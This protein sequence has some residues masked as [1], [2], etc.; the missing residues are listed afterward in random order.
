MPIPPDYDEPTKKP[1]TFTFPQLDWAFL[2]VAGIVCVMI[3]DGDL[4]AIGN[5]LTGSALTAFRFI[6]KQRNE[7]GD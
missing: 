5:Q 4:T 6:V 1:K 7:D 3:S 2:L